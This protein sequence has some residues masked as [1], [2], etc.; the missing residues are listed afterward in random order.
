MQ[1]V[2]HLP[3]RPVERGDI[4]ILNDRGLHVVPYGGVE[5]D[6]EMRIYA[7]KLATDSTAYAL[8]FDESAR[9]WQQISSVEASN[10]T[11]TERY[12]DE[13]LNEWVLAQYGDRFRVMKSV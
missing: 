4:R 7:V 9:T 12:L 3:R 5:E 8:G 10:L 1:N 6:G 13:A 2:T 11:E